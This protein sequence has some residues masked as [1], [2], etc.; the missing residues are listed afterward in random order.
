MLTY[1]SESILWWHWIVLGSLLLIIEMNIGTF[2]FLGLGLAAVA[3]GLIDYLLHISLLLEIAIWIALSVIAFVAWLKWYKETTVSATGQSNYGLDIQG[4]VTE[5]IKPNRR[6]KVLFDSP[7]LGNTL[8]HATSTEPIPVGSR[9]KISEV[10]GQLIEVKKIQ[11][12]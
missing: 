6:G 3:V 9:V 1:L 10:N 4:E 7:V 12:E 5:E 2:L 11:G 8:W